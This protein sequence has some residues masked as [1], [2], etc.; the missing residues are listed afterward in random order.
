MKKPDRD[1]EYLVRNPRD[2]YVWVNS[3]EGEDVRNQVLVGRR[4]E[5]GFWRVG[6]ILEGDFTFIAK[7]F[8]GGAHYESGDGR[9]VV[10]GNYQIL[11]CTPGS[12]EDVK[13][14]EILVLL[15]VLALLLT[16][17]AFVLGYFG[18]LYRHRYFKFGDVVGFQ[19]M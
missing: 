12:G 19:K 15:M 14:S 10:A 13:D 4:V 17:F 11:T 3:S 1:V 6:R 2:N 16:T 8:P 18:F 7:V 5:G 9:E